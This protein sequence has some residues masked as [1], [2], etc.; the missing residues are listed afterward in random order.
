M[1]AALYSVKNFESIVFDRANQG[2]IHKLTYFAEP[3][4]ATTT[5]QAEG[6]AL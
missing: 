3:L 6:C 2:K 1:K 4:N 5:R